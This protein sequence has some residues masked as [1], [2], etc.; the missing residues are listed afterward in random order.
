M[1]DAIEEAH[2][3]VHHALQPLRR[4][5]ARMAILD[6]A[7]H[8]RAVVDVG[9]LLV[10]LLAVMGRIR[11][12]G[13]ILRLHREACVA[14][15][16][17][18]EAFGSLDE[19][20]V[21]RIVEGGAILYDSVGVVSELEREQEHVILIAELL[22]HVGDISA[23]H[24]GLCGRAHDEL[25]AIEFVDVVV[26]VP[27][28]LLADLL[29]ADLRLRLLPPVPRGM[30]IE[31]ATNLALLDVLLSDAHAMEEVHDV[32]CHEDD[33]VLLSRPD[34]LVTVL[35]AQCDRLLA[36]DMLLVPGRTDHRH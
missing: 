33:T 32:A 25:D 3:I 10:E 13:S 21:L 30:G 36:E 34:H 14:H 17:A 12:D 22:S 26:E 28:G 19:D 35:V 24:D 31:D 6:G 15:V 16:D 18:D 7:V 23:D 20:V 9:P 4:Q 27:T 29:P 2:L 8:L 5:L 1:H 11:D